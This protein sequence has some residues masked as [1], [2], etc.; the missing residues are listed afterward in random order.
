MKHY[1]FRVISLFLACYLGVVGI[2]L[3]QVGKSLTVSSSLSEDPV[4]ILDA[5]HRE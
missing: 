1:R 4:I 3:S 2:L 5:G